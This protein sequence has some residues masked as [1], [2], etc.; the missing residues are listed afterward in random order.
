MARTLLSL[1]LVLAVILS[2][3]AQSKE[4][5]ALIMPYVQTNNYSGSV[6]IAQNG[7]V[8]FS[9]A[10]GQM[11]RTYNLPNTP[12]T[13]FF[14][15]SASMIFTSAAIMKLAE[16]KKIS[17]DDPVAKYLPDYKPGNRLTL[18]HLLSQRSGIPAIGVNQKVDYDSITK[19]QH[20]VD[21]LIHYFK[22]D[23]L[24]FPPGS[25][26]NHSRSDYIVLAYIIE[27]VTGKPFG[28]YLKESIFDPLKLTNTGHSHGESEIIPNLANGYA[29]VGHYEVE[30]AYQIN[31]TSKTGH[32][33]IYSTTEDLYKFSTAITNNKLLSK[34]SWQKIFTDYGD[35]VGYGWFIRN[36]L[37]RKRVQMNGRSPG[38]SSY[39]GIYPD[40]NLTV[41]ALSNN[42]I[43]L[44]ANLGMQLAALVLKK[45]APKTNLTKRAVA[46]EQAS[47]LVGKYQFDSNFYVKDLVMEVSY[48]EGNLSCSW[49][50]LI[51]VADAK[52]PDTKFIQ[53]TYWSDVEFT[54]NS[55]G[56]IE[57]ML[58]DGHKGVKVKGL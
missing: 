31:W 46:P 51:P 12:Q 5:D 33:S 40:D 20:S 6:L 50:A 4:I 55:Q 8:L 17:L 47:R 26:Y 29:A 53:R 57:A 10:Y 44:P 52:K 32:G 13:K 58:V 9:K 21:Q 7:K 27:K 39:F 48:K 14:L 28:S 24:L 45:P 43:S 15:A 25:K 35:N 41:I 18:H 54:E 49:G 19:F 37:D 42:Y 2:T 16:E 23:S 22:E 56:E 3:K 11:N 36:H 34:E 38:F 1:G 30:N